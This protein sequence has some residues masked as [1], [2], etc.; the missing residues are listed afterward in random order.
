VIGILQRLSFCREPRTLMI[1]L[2]I[3]PMIFRIFKN[4]QLSDFAIQFLTAMMMNLSLKRA[5]RTDFEK[6][7]GELVSIV[8]QHLTSDNNEVRNHINGSL[9]LLLTSREIRAEALR[10]KLDRI[11]KDLLDTRDDDMCSQQYA[12]ILK[13]LHDQ[14]DDLDKDDDSDDD[15]E[16]DIEEY[17]EYEDEDYGSLSD[18]SDGCIEGE[19]EIANGEE[20]LLKNYV[21]LG[22]EAVREQILTRSVL[23]ETSRRLNNMTTSI[24]RSRRMD[25]IFASKVNATVL[26]PELLD[27]LLNKK[28]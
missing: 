6:H 12:Y 27:H 5:S 23:D 9:F 19:I 20:L 10:Q 13:R 18:S 2:G 11:I 24:N 14:E 3:V 28:K 15:N 7:K 1:Q 16:A 26:E 21:L 25:N 22:P 17:E 8:I 4:E